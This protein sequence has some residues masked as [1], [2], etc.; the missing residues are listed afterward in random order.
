MCYLRMKMSHPRGRYFE[1]PPFPAFSHVLPTYCTVSYLI[2]L[3][4][5]GTQFPYRRVD[6]AVQLLQNVMLPA[7]YPVISESLQSIAEE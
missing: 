3:P 6:P 2:L 1:L 7:P 5:R 4:A